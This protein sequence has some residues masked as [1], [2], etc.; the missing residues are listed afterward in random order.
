[1]D[2]SEQMTTNSKKVEELSN[3]AVSVESK[4]NELS[5][6]MSDATHMAETTVTNYVKTGD[7]I[8]NIINDISK[9]NGLSTQN[10]RSVEEIASAAE[11][12][13]K[14]T[15]TLNDKLDEFKTA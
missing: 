2:S 3:T 4:I 14:M 7:D 13:N 1:M 11:H 8:G 5:S 6:I 10:A 15:E 9:I 12:M